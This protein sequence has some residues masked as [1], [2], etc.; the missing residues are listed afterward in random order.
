MTPPVRIGVMGC[1]DIARRRMLPAMSAADD[2]EVVA[3]A[4]RTGPTAREVA[5]VYGC[6][7]VAGY[8]AL[9]ALAEVDAVYIPLPLALHA[10]WAERALRAGRHVLV[11]KPLTADPRETRR[12]LDLASSRGLVL[13]ENVMFVHHRQHDAVRRL[14]RRGAIGELRS[15]HAEF[16]V[17]RLPDQDIRYQPELGGGALWDIGLY[18]LRA[19]T[20]FLG[21]DL[22]VVGAALGASPGR[23]V[24]TSGAVLLRRRDGVTAQLSFGLEH[25]YASRYQ[26]CG[27]TG[28]IQVDR[29]F[30]PPSDHVPVIRVDRGTGS[31]EVPLVPDDQVRNSLSAF[32]AAVRTGKADDAVV[33]SCIRQAGLLALVSE[34]GSW[35]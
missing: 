34:G 35:K 6:R 27:S 24:D 5:G 32:T 30:T 29:A 28:R 19:A 13:M 25:A 17:P 9:L 23:R 12:L 31:R 11:E 15:F 18:P 4:S 1:A 3:V 21:D 2:I 14:V 22:E 16:A 20:H 33:H 10:R 7:S 26:L 8:D